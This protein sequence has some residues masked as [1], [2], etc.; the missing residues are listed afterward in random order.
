[1][2]RIAI[3]DLQ[4]PSYEYWVELNDKSM[5][6]SRKSNLRITGFYVSLIWVFWSLCILM[7]V[8]LALNFLIA[9]VSQSY[10]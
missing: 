10:E 4:P 8:I 5:I 2:F 6:N 3:G 9:I 1:M 7:N